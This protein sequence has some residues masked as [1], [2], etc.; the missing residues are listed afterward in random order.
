RK[1]AAGAIG[2]IL[3]LPATSQAGKVKVWNHYAAGHYEKAHLKHAV[4]TSEGSVKLS[5]RLKPLA[6]I[7]AGHVWSVVEDRAG[8]LFA[9]T[10]DEGKILKISPS[11]DVSIAFASEDSQVFSLATAADGDIYAGTGPSGQ[12]I[13]LTSEGKTEIFFKSPEAYIWSLAI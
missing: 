3:A 11:G 5:R 6:S 12:I 4:V 7:H 8:N 13:R 10:G 1:L 9:A 2:I